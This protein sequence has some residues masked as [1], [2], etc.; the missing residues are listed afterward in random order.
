MTAPLTSLPVLR[1][2]ISGD[3]PNGPEQANQE[4][5]VSPEGAIAF[6]PL[7]SQDERRLRVVDTTGSILA[8]FG[9]T[10]RGPGELQNPKRLFFADSRLDVYDWANLRLTSYSLSGKAQGQRQYDGVV[11]PFAVHG[12]SADVVAMSQGRFVVSREGLR[13]PA[14]GWL[15][16]G[17]SILRVVFTEPFLNASPDDQQQF[18]PATASTSDRLIL[19]AGTSYRLY[20]Y[21]RD[22][23]YLGSFGRDLPPEHPTKR[24]AE[25]AASSLTGWRGPDGKRMDPVAVARMASEMRSKT[26][27]YFSHT[28]SL[29]FDGAGRLWV[30]GVSEDT[31]FADI[32]ADTAFLGRVNLGCPD[33]AQSW[34]LNGR[35]LALLCGAPEAAQGSALL[36]LF[37]LI[38]QP[39]P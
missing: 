32:F 16:V 28:H 2:V 5:A 22:G 34:S 9:R 7:E 14:R 4:I 20:R 25:R 19:G 36:K 29:G 27:P 12:D 15:S 10:G 3:F 8:A 26:V 17:D 11:F 37:E 21:D 6:A 23:R 33:F 30:L 1:P 35:W 31:T 38:E 24:A 13:G 39:S 18:F